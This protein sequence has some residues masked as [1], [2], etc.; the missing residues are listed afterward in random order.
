MI[1]LSHL[2]YNRVIKYIKKGEMNLKKNIGILF[3]PIFLLLTSPV[4]AAT[5]DSVQYESLGQKVMIVALITIAFVAIVFELFSKGIGFAGALGFLSLSYFFFMQ[6]STGFASAE[7]LFIFVIGISLIVLEC[8]IPGAVAGIIGFFAIVLGFVMAV[9]NAEL[10]FIAL[11]TALVLSGLL[12]YIM[13]KVLKKEILFYDAFVLKSSATSEKGYVSHINRTDL[14]GVK[15]KSLTTLRP[16]GTAI[17]NDERVD[18]VTLGDFI[19]QG[20]EIEVVQVEGVRI[21]VKE[22]LS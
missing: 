2:R 5:S 20:K 11:F 15:G 6:L 19:E 7:S 3:L 4:Y 21:V 22:V 18:V 9:G 10:A 16:A 13:R 8:F 14:I 1:L 12:F 17:I